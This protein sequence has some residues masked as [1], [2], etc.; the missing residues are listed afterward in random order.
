[1]LQIRATG[2]NKGDQL[3]LMDLPRLYQQKSATGSLEK[4]SFKT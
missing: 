3:F 2:V 4:A 1:M